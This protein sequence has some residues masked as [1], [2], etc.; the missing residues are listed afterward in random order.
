MSRVVIS[1][2]KDIVKR[3][4]KALLKL[5]PNL[6][7]KNSKILIKPNLVEPFPK[8][9]G[10]VTRPE[11]VEGIIKYLNSVGKYKLIIGEG[12]SYT[13]RTRECFEKAGYYYLENKYDIKIIPFDEK[14]FVLVKLNGEKWKEI[15]VSKIAKESD[16]IISA[17]VLKE[18]GYKVTLALKNMMG[19]LEPRGYY[20]NKDYMH[21]L[22]FVFKG[23]WSK[24]LC[25]LLT[26]FRP[27]LSVID[28]TTAMYGSHLYGEL[29]QMDLTIVGEDP[30][31]VDS[32]A[33]NILG[34]E[35]VFYIEDAE[36]RGI[37][38]KRAEIDKI[39]I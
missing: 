12:C 29:K 17:P 11:V 38:S 24:R 34:H 10:A 9:S 21:R 2:G 13:G 31:A 1:K 20:P 27:D 35:K 25:D 6:P 15:K 5:K 16:Y 37:G 22:G 26:K 19:I 28:G 23:G 8:D 14:E 30:V 32:V 39:I 7:P 36:K 3:T 4:K 33:S 18:H